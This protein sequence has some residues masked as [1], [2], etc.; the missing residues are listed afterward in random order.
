MFISKWWPPSAAIL[1]TYNRNIFKSKNPISMQFAS[2]REVFQI[3]LDKIHLYFCDPFP[4]ILMSIIFTQYY[5]TGSTLELIYFVYIIVGGVI[6]D[7]AAII[8]MCFDICI[9]EHKSVLQRMVVFDLGLMTA[10][11]LLKVNVLLCR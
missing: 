2:K 7:N 1:N 5:L 9:V 8:K 10:Y 4:L 6:P 11:V 3:L